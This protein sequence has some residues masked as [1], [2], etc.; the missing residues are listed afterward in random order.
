VTSIPPDHPGHLDYS[1]HADVS[2][3]LPDSLSDSLSDQAIVDPNILEKIAHYKVKSLTAARGELVMPCIPSLQDRYLAQI[4]ALLVSLGQ[5]FSAQEKQTLAQI[6]SKNL[7][8]G[9]AKS[10]Y[11]RL[12]FR[13]SPPTPTTGLTKGLGINIAAEVPSTE[14]KYQ[15]WVDTREGALFG[16]H[17]D[18]KVMAVVKSLD[19]AEPNQLPILDIGA[20]TGRNTFP[21]ARLGYPID[22]IELAPVFV[23]Q[24]QQTATTEGLGINVIQG[25]VLE[26][27]LK[28]RPAHYGFIFAAEVI[29]HFR[30]INEVELLLA[31]MCDCLRSRGLLLFNLFLTDEGYEPTPMI[32]E[33]AQV[34]WSFL[35][36]PT[37][38]ATVLQKLPLEIITNQSVYDYELQ[39]LPT[40][41]WPPTNWFP[42]W[43]RG[44]DLFPS[45]DRQPPVS[46]RW[47][48][49][50]RT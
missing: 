31:R 17:A 38:L 36:T 29:P 15:R 43:S 34:A 46:L 13:Y 39:N 30:H 47:L 20:G 14:E 23:E 25:N 35:V 10:P 16:S 8:E 4:N 27:E 33:L 21:L 41:A 48:L 6:V 44:R 18:A 42:N 49:C 50:R 32:R 26:P 24:L 45:S 2:A 37:E 5:N 3:S 40:E 9:F 11:A 1:D 7:Q 12:I 19:A 28:L 22:A